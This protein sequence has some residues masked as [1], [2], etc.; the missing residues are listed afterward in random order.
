MGA[1]RAL[2]FAGL[3]LTLFL[4]RIGPVDAANITVTTT[5]DETIANGQTSLREAFTT[6]NGNG[7]N[8]TITLQAG[9][10]YELDFCVAGP[11]THTAPHSLTIQGGAGTSLHNTCIE[12]QTIV[13]ND[14]TAGL[15]INSLEM[16]GFLVDDSAF[17]DG[18]AIDV[19][20]GG[21]L[22][23]SG[24][25]IHGFSSGGGSIVNGP[26]FASGSVTNSEIW[27]NEGT[28][29]TGSFG[30]LTLTNSEVRDNDGRGVALVDG[31]PLTISGSSVNDNTGSGATTTGQG[32]TDA[33]ITNSHFDGNG[34]LGFSC[35]A[36]DQVS[37]SGSTV[38]GNG[39]DATTGAGFGGG[40]IKVAWDVDGLEDAPVLSITNSTVA[41][42]RAVHSGGGVAV[43]ILEASEPAAAAPALN[44]SG[45]NI[46]A[47]LTELDL[48]IDG[49]GIYAELGNIS[50]TN[51]STI[52][53]NHAGPAGG[54]TSAEGG[55]IW[56][57]DLAAMDGAR[58]LSITNS[59]VSGN[60]ANGIGGGVYA[61]HSG[62]VSVTGSTLDD[63]LAGGGSGGAM[64]TFGTATTVTTSKVQGNDADTGGGLAHTSFSGLPVGSLTVERSTLSGNTSSFAASGGGGIFVNVGGAGALATVRNSTVTGNT[65]ANFG[66]GIMVMQTSRLTVNHA[67][68]V[69]NTGATGANVYVAAGDFRTRRAA[70]ALPHGSGNC[71]FFSAA[72]VSEGFSWAD[73]VTCNLGGTDVEAPGVNP[74]LA[75][76]ANNGGPTPTRKPSPSTPLD[77][78]PAGSCTIGIDQR[79]TGRPLGPNC[80]AGAVE[81]DETASK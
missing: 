73:D 33:T 35:S 43:T 54:A 60:E 72:T 37:I 52:N 29:Y 21:P 47:N 74:Q 40:G 13:D 8:D 59:T 7:Q 63:N 15:T 27:G 24:V 53:N 36:C 14:T 70:I 19:A 51:G 67:T 23:L 80:E 18:A 77:I 41:F 4:V 61:A 3:L 9:A 76:L 71:A 58:S 62:T 42:N 45:S 78:V 49:A 56:Q 79:G 75:A 12:S 10:D 2:V 55:G 22:T 30:G 28:G 46:S 39:Q 5:A 25:E 69:D 16:I 32:H 11:L 65:S 6:A 17:V 31:T 64:A 48:D 1:R 20:E 57:R 34:D 44:V 68:V 26:D 66:G 38:A 81:I 50:V